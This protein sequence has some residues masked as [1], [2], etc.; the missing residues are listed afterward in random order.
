[1]K[2]DTFTETKE[3]YTEEFIDYLSE[4]LRGKLLS[5]KIEKLIKKLEEKRIAIPH[6][7]WLDVKEIIDLLR[8]ELLVKVKAAEKDLER[9]NINGKQFIYRIRKYRQRALQ[10]K[11]FLQEKKILS[12]F[13]FTTLAYIGLSAMWIPSAITSVPAFL[14][15]INKGTGVPAQP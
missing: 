13:D 14:E 9:G 4:S 11:K 12:K 3:L 6:D 8:D 1:M 2:L 10:V 15:M 5:N 7:D